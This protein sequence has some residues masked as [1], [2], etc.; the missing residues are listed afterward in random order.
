[1]S[2][3]VN[4]YSFRVGIIR[5]WK[6]R[7]FRTKNYKEFL[8]ADIMLREWLHKR[9]EGMYVSQIE[10]ERSRTDFNL[11][12]KTSRPGLLIGRGGEGVEKLRQ[13][14]GALGKKYKLSLPKNFKISVEEVRAPETH[15]AIVSQMIA[16]DLKKRVN[17]RRVLK[18]TLDKIMANKEVKG[19]KIS[20]SGRLGGAEMAR[21][22]WLKKGQVPLTTLRADI[23]F[24]KGRAHLPYGD[25]GI[26]VWI[27]KGEIFEKEKQVK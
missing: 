4:P 6:S 1:M 15:S 18:Q 17:F 25:I 16:D 21:Y 7:W 11:I 26:K 2:H 27:Y 9:L 13:E 20:L 14:I 3:S 8:K 19:A 24:A 22:E 23:D 10:I 12:I 5:D